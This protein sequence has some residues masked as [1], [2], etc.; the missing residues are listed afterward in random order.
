[1]KINLLLAANL[2]DSLNRIAFEWANSLGKMGHDV[3]VSVPRLNHIDYHW[4]CYQKN[5]LRGG[6]LAAIFYLIRD[7]GTKRVFGRWK[8]HSIS[9]QSNKIRVNR[10]FLKAN[11][12]NMPDADFIIALNGIYLIPNLLSL[13]RKKGEVISSIHMNYNRAIVDPDETVAE[14][15]RL[16]VELEKRINVRRFAESAKNVEECRSLN[17]PVN[18]VIFPGVNLEQFYPQDKKIKTKPILKVALF[19]HPRSH[20]GLEDGIKVIEKVREKY[21]S[22]LITFCTLGDVGDFNV[23]VF[24]RIIYF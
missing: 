3:I 23:S 16:I 1:L 21:P 11:E 13:P 14:W 7:L 9:S 6:G 18:G 8:G 5:C 10:F 20:K 17:I 15:Y 12:L 19:C 4:W 2:N 22:S 24:D